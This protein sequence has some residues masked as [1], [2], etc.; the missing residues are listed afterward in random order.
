M[1]KATTSTAEKRGQQAGDGVRAAAVTT[2]Y[3][4][5]PPGP[6]HIPDTGKPGQGRDHLYSVEGHLFWNDVD[7][8]NL[9]DASSKWTQA[10]DEKDAPIYR[11]GNVGIGTSKPATELDVAGI[12]SARGLR[13]QALDGVAKVSR[14]EIVGNAVLNDMAD[15]STIDAEQGQILM[16]GDGGWFAAPPEGT[17]VLSHEGLKDLDAD[18]HPQY[19]TA[20][21]HAA[22]GH[23]IPSLSVADGALT[24]SRPEVRVSTHL[25]VQGDV[26]MVGRSG[27]LVARR[28]KVSADA[29]TDDVPE[30]KDAKFHT[31]DRVAE[32]GDRRYLRLDGSNI[33]SLHPNGATVSGLDADSI[34]GKHAADFAPVDHAH[35]H[36]TLSGIGED[37]H[38]DRI[39]RL[40][41]PDHAA[42]DG[43][44][45]G[46]V[47]LVM[48]DNRVGFGQMELSSTAGRLPI[49]RVGDGKIGQKE[50]STLDGA[51][52]SLQAQIDGKA[53]SDH[54]HPHSDAPDLDQDHHAQYLTVERAERWL[55][56]K[57]TD[58]IRCGAS[59]RYVD[60]D[61]V[62]DIASREH[63][64]IDGGNAPGETIPGLDADM[65]D[66]IHGSELA[67]ADHAHDHASLAG[68]GKDDH[69]PE[70][71]DI[72]SHRVNP[73]FKSG[74]VLKVKRGEIEFDV[75]TA[76]DMP[77][78]MATAE[79]VADLSDKVKGH[80]FDI[81]SKAEASHAH[82]HA[83]LAEM[84]ADD[85]PQYL[86]AE[87]A[88]EL[89]SK[90]TTDDIREG[91]DNRYFRPESARAAVS[92]L[93][94][95]FYDGD[96]RLSVAIDERH[97]QIVD[98][99]LTI[100]NAVDEDSH[101]DVAS[102]I[103]D[104]GK[105]TA[106]RNEAVIRV[107]TEHEP[108]DLSVEGR[109]KAKRLEI[110]SL[111]GVVLA[112]DGVISARASIEDLS[113]VDSN[114]ADGDVLLF[115]D[116]RWV[117]RR[118]SKVLFEIQGD[119]G[120]DEDAVKDIHRSLPHDVPSLVVG[121]GVFAVD[122]TK[123]TVAINTP[124]AKNA[125]D[126]NGGMAVGRE[127]AGAIE[128]DPGTIIASRSIGVGRKDDPRETLDVGTGK[129]IGGTNSEAIPNV[130]DLSSGGDIPMSSLLFHGGGS[131]EMSAG[132][133]M[134]GIRLNTKSV[135]SVILAHNPK[136]GTSLAVPRDGK[137][138][139][140]VG[141]QESIAATATGLGIGVREP[142]MRLDV[143][144]HVGVSDGSSNPKSWIIFRAAVPEA[145]P[146]ICFPADTG[147]QVGTLKSYDS[148]SVW[149]ATA[150]FE[151]DGTLRLSGRLI[152]STK[153]IKL[154][155]GANEDLEIEA[156]SIVKLSTDETASIG[157]LTDGF[158][159]ATVTLMNVGD[160]TIKLSGESPGSAREN[161]IAIDGTIDLPT[162]RCVM[163][164]YDGDVDRW[165]PSI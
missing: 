146:T 104:G 73:S 107:G 44:T 139:I 105:L 89:V 156:A 9:A 145:P 82:R 157:G 62:S 6:V 115:E 103:V 61:E 20:A 23:A 148:G 140:K 96:G 60:D 10:A 112:K 76:D 131:I 128:V 19:L 123:G 27:I 134:A 83:D 12:I 69:H 155:S 151:A 149:D 16:R 116:D 41:G 28:G 29:T 72:L 129:I 25:I 162:K 75:L 121:Q 55:S 38:H 47:L 94:P 106:S 130:L 100:K 163:L 33:S 98:D 56:G 165:I 71:H 84:D 113:N 39:H 49:H 97:L 15:V 8:T 101:L 14:G 58:D 43:A 37:D 81:R 65:V 86:N 108:S 46:S 136:E 42:P 127:V 99:K 88:N 53:D 79:S 31:P 51:R 144:G 35:G 135:G 159:G 87:R 32:V 158:D 122:P 18:G 24:A 77:F 142:R 126:V 74:S 164:V 30:G 17:I 150:S 110:E 90:T 70:T 1:N 59:N 78:P 125:L 64:R 152:A 143:R 50:L 11:L 13:L 85:H 92:P 5:K 141:G 52:G 132:E 91:R 40:D 111:D 54:G 36:S 137:F 93:T 48:G 63:L 119:D 21:R 34:D 102:I 133:D 161:R 80:D 160:D 22:T 45:A 57:T 153:K 154:E 138:G 3:I 124:S 7:L 117:S 118:L 147:L 26:T 2:H 120:I 109:V 68:I 4:E 66:G 114:A 67:R 95:L